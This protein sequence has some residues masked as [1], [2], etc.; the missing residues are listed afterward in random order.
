MGRVVCSFYIKHSNCPCEMTVACCT[1]VLRYT[2]D[3]VSSFHSYMCFWSWC[4]HDSSQCY[5]ELNLGRG[6]GGV[7]IRVYWYDTG[8]QFIHCYHYYCWLWCDIGPFS[9]CFFNF[10]EKCELCITVSV[11][12]DFNVGLFFL[13]ILHDD[14]IHGAWHMTPVLVIS[15]LTFKVT[16][17]SE[18]SSC[19]L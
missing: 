17:V 19:K 15:L 18:R 4:M 8:S 1:L 3:C 13:E 11:G 6:R 14:E 7:I 5:F 9:L 2:C 16:G 10:R 12:T